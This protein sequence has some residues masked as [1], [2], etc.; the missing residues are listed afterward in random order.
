MQPQTRKPRLREA[1]LLVQSYSGSRRCREQSSELKDAR[2]CNPDTLTPSG[3]DTSLPVLDCPV[4]NSLN[5]FCLFLSL[6]PEKLRPIASAKLSP[7]Q[8]YIQFP[9]VSTRLRTVRKEAGEMS[10]FSCPLLPALGRHRAPYAHHSFL[11]ITWDRHS[12]GGTQNRC[13]RTSHVRMLLAPSPLTGT[14]C[15]CCY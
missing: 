7:S 6:S 11:P 10:I 15:C 8:N 2:T 12:H 9:V 4:G 3:T 1:R 5:S 13:A 14:Q